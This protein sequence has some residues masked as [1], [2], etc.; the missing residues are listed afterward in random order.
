MKKY[1]LIFIFLLPGCNYVPEI[2]KT[3]DDIATDDAITIKCDKDCFQKETNVKIN[4]EVTNK[5]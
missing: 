3:I 5:P 2:S 1:V 4:L